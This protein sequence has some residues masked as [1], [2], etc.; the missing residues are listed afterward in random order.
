MAYVAAYHGGMQVVDFSN[1]ATPQVAAGVPNSF[2][3]RDVALG[4]RYAVAADA[5]FINAVPIVDLG[6]PGD[7]ILR[8]F[9]NFGDFGN[10]FGTGIAVNDQYIYVTGSTDGANTDNGSNGDSRLFIGEYKEPEHDETDTGG[11]APTVT[12]A[13]P[14]DGQAVAESSRLPV[15]IT[16]TD[17]VQIGLVQ[18]IVNGVVV[19]KDVAARYNITYKVPVGLTSLT[20][21]ARA[22][23]VAGNATT[24]APVTLSVFE[25][26][27]PTITITVPV[28]GQQ[29]FEEECLLLTAD[30]TDNGSVE[31]VVFT[32]NGETIGGGVESFGTGSCYFVPTGATS[33]VIVA[34]A[35]DDFGHTASATRTVSVVPDPPPTANIVSPLEGAQLTEGEVVRFTAEVSDNIAVY[36]VIFRIDGGEP[37]YDFDVPYTYTFNVPLGVSSVTLEVEAHDNR[38]QIGLA[39]RTYAVVPDPGTTVTGRVVDTS[40][41]PVPDATVTVF[42]EFTTQTAADGTFSLLNV[43]SVRGAIVARVTATIDNKSAA[44][45][46]LPKPPIASGTTDLGD[47]TL[48]VLPTAPTVAGVGNYNSDGQRDVFVGYPDRLSLIY[49]FIGGEFVPSPSTTLPYGAVSSGAISKVTSSGSLTKIFTQGVGQPGS[50]TDLVF[51]H[52]QMQT[53]VTLATGLA[54]EAAY[55][56]ASV[57]QHHRP[58]VLAFL[59]ATGDTPLTVRFR[60]PNAVSDEFDEEADFNAP[61]VVPVGSSSPLRTLKLADVNDDGLQDIVAIKPVS[62][63]DARLVVIQRATAT[64]APRTCPALLSRRPFLI[65]QVRGKVITRRS[66]SALRPT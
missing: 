65:H 4:R 62:G 10:Y 45:A 60:N 39:S 42:N 24:S 53:P 49:E 9:V 20:I 18:L 66:T 36:Y 15:S 7:P 22:F 55:T 63:T 3:P 46:S 13:S 30:A 56:A 1:P 52:S 51:Q 14:Q 31:S 35:T 44:N 16:A 8:G 38:D 6:D 28:E 32:V 54:Q 19:I 48:S 59:A 34:T 57:D 64:T 58:D 47:I 2:F 27:P 37:Q 40:A 11:M 61:I 5:R 43:P 41:Q 12:I 25:D 29:V 26:P 23:D 50:I 17:D 21:E 33:L